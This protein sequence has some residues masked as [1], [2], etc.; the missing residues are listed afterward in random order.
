VADQPFLHLAPGQLDV[1][2]Q[3]EHARAMGEGLVRRDLGRGEACRAHGE[4]ERIAM[5]VENA[6]AI[7]RAER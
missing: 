1:K 2:L 4:I 3:R 7:D 6:D 5:P